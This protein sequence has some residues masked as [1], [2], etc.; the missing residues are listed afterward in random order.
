MFGATDLTRYVSIRLLF[1][2][3]ALCDPRPIATPQASAA[4]A[5]FKLICLAFSVPPVILEI[6]IGADKFFLNKDLDNSTSEISSSG[7]AT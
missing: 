2:R 6:S 7:R 5:K 4:I 1:S 3:A